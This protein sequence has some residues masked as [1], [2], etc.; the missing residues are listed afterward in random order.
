ML[1]CSTKR[2]EI[3]ASAS[4]SDP[5]EAPLSVF[6]NGALTNANAAGLKIRL[7]F[8]V[9]AVIVAPTVPV[10]PEN[11]IAAPLAGEAVTVWSGPLV[12]MAGVKVSVAVD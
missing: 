3:F 1:Y 11:V 6:D 10:A 4:R 7:T 12:M 9:T 2:I 5:T 8:D